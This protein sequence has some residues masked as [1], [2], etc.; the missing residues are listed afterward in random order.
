M[1]GIN[2]EVSIIAN[3]QYN[4][5]CRPTLCRPD[6]YKIDGRTMADKLKRRRDLMG[7]GMKYYRY[8]SHYVNIVGS[9]KPEYFRVSSVPGQSR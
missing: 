4:G 7:E 8:L 2:N 3:G 6:I 9:N 1:E 5:R